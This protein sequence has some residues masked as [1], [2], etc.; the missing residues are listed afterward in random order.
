MS[1]FSPLLTWIFVLALA[2]ALVSA[3]PNSRRQREK[4]ERQD[5]GPGAK[6]SSAKSSIEWGPSDIHIP[7]GDFEDSELNDHPYFKHPDIVHGTSHGPMLENPNAEGFL[8]AQLQEDGPYD[9]KAMKFV[10]PDTSAA[11]LHGPGVPAEGVKGVPKS[12]ETERREAPSKKL[13]R[14]N[15][16]KIVSLKNGEEGNHPDNVGNA[17]LSKKKKKLLRKQRR[18]ELKKAKDAQEK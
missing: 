10:T 14:E 3:K 7:D 4:K 6:D 9:P 1:K 2:V 16:G 15:Q 5:A 12:Y 13:R 8:I 11:E 18:Q 17:K